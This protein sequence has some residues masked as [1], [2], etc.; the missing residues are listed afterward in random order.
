MESA[1]TTPPPTRS[2][3]ASATAVL[4]DAVG[5]KIAMT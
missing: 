3:T 1:D 5:P 4:P 2:A